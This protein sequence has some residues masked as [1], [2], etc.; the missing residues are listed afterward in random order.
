MT[1]GYTSTEGN[2]VASQRLA[3]N[4]NVGARP[5]E[6]LNPHRRVSTWDAEHLANQKRSGVGQ[7]NPQWVGDIAVSPQL[8]G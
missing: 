5:E 3:E 8:L 2:D 6:C 1:E 7:D 4:Q